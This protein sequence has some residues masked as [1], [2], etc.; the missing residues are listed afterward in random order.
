MHGARLAL[1]FAAVLA[2]IPVARAFSTSARGPFGRATADAPKRETREGGQARDGGPERAALRTETAV[3]Q[4]V[5]VTPNESARRVD[6]TIGGKPFTSYIWPERVKKE[7]LDPIR[8]AS[9][10]IVTRGWRRM[11]R[12]L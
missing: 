7:V 1:S 3:P 9:G 11:R 6:V 8:S 12:T 4:A 10:T 5:A 2:M